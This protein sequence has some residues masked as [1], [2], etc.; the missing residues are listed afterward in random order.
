LPA[1][2]GHDFELVLG[3]TSAEEPALARLR[4]GGWRIRDRHAVADI[5]SYL[6]YIAGSRAEIGIAKGAYVV[7]RAGWIGDRSCH[8]LASGKPVLAQSTGIEGS[9]PVGEGLVTFSD[10]EEAAEAASAIALDH[11][12]HARAA[13]QLAHELFD[14]RRVLPSLLERALAPHAAREAAAP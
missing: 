9:L 2:S 12:R 4:A 13:K 1:Q 11:Q 6:R 10:L 8:Y 7:G 5:P 14:H 3:S